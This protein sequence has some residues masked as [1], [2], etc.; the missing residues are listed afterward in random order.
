VSHCNPIQPREARGGTL[1][2]GGGFAGSYV[3]R[4][5][6]VPL[7]SMC[8]DADL[9]LGSAVALDPQR[10]V[11]TVESEAGSFEVVH[12]DLVIARPQGPR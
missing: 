6:T 12:E 2:L 11:V 1:I 4:H 8:P 10:K 7:R 9:L 3:A 5:V